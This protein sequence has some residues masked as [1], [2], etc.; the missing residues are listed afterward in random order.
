M[1]RPESLRSRAS[2]P[3]EVPVI[4]RNGSSGG[5]RASRRSPA[6]VTRTV[7]AALLAVA[8][9]AG[10]GATGGDDA[11]PAPSSSASSSTAA[12][13]A[14]RASATPSRHHK[15][16]RGRHRRGRHAGHA[17]RSARPSPSRRARPTEPT[18]RPRTP[19]RK[20]KPRHTSAAPKP[21]RS[22]S[23][24]VAAEHA[25]WKRTNKRRAAHGCHALRL[26]SRLTK[27][28]RGH[29]RDMGVHDYFAHDSRNGDSP[30]DRIKAQ[31]YDHPSAENIAKGYA[32]PKAVLSGWMHSSGHRANILNC[33][34]Q[35]IGV[36][37]WYGPG[38]PIWTQDFGFN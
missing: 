34:Y 36:G 18:A 26:D 12:P 35:A 38:G 24:V 31:G 1:S 10:C 37:V 27:A 17:H 19:H 25:V 33:D 16:Q 28:A 4:P 9:A 14:T 8:L 20:P 21:K 7:A 6:S 32:T 2:D 23:K 29:S 15:S 30:W 13:L 11:A 5:P 22:T 3:L